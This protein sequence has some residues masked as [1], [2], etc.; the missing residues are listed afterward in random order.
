[1]QDPLSFWRQ[2]TEPGGETVIRPTPRP[3]KVAP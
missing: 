1:V 2:V 3:V